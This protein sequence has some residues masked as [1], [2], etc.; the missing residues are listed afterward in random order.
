M[1][2]SYNIIDV[3]SDL[4]LIFMQRAYS[5]YIKYSVDLYSF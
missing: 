3:G 5:K 2:A 4:H 1:F